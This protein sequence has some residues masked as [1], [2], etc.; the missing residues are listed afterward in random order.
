MVRRLLCGAMLTLPLVTGAHL[1]A[2]TQLAAPEDARAATRYSVARLGQ[3]PRGGDPQDPG[4]ALYQEGYRLILLEK[5]GEARQKFDELLK[6]HPRS[7]YEDA[8]RYWSAYA[9]THTQREK[10]LTAYEQF[11]HQ[12]A[13]SAYYDDAVAD[14][15]RLLRTAPD[16]SHMIVMSMNVRLLERQ[17]RREARE[18]SR[19]RIAAPVP[20]LARRFVEV[21]GV[22]EET[23]LRMEAVRALGDASDGEASFTMLRGIALDHSQPRPLRETAM[24]SMV[25]FTNPG[26]VQVYVDIA[27]KDTSEILRQIAVDYIGEAPI[28]KNQKVTVLIQLYKTTPRDRVEQRE[29]IFYSIADVGNDAAVDFLS[30]VALTGQDYDLRRD[31]VYYLGSIGGERARS[32]LT[33]ILRPQ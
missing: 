30:D 21:E 10:A 4:H 12:H 18:L 9:L 27:R 3:V 16:T 33:R 17:L 26:V 2:Q 13:S 24:E 6:K 14:M 29:A 5:W 25:G 28:D 7:S 32:A 22:D 23:L 11:V 8:A 15:A 20:P 19:L 31:A 1:A